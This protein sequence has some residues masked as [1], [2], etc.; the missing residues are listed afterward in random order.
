M[1]AD[2][3]GWTRS[4]GPDV[5]SS[6]LEQ[7]CERVPCVGEATTQAA[8]GQD[9][10]A[11]C[12]EG[13]DDFYLCI[14]DATWK[15]PATAAAHGGASRMPHIY[16]Y[17]HMGAGSTVDLVFGGGEGGESVLGPPGQSIAPN[18]RLL[19]AVAY[20]FEH[21][22][23]PSH[24]RRA[25]TAQVRWQWRAKAR[26]V[27]WPMLLKLMGACCVP[28]H[29]DSGARITLAGGLR[30]YP[31]MDGWNEAVPSSHAQ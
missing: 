20:V 13:A 15:A 4:F 2:E 29:P 18:A 14:F 22:A 28:A 16:I 3:G 8:G 31:R 12:R 30:P 21:V 24:R 26:R 5:I 19:I 7:Q 10:A 25:H 6:G 9:Y 27:P 17:I 11:E 23:R 1:I